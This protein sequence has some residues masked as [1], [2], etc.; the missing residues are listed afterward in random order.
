MCLGVMKMS[1]SLLSAFNIDIRKSRGINK[2]DYDVFTNKDLLDRFRISILENLSDRVDVDNLDKDALI[3]EVKVALEG[4]EV[5]NEERLYLYNL[6]DNEINGYG[7]LTELLVAKDID[8]I[9][10]N[11]CDEV[12]VESNGRLI[13]DNNVS[14]IN[15]KHIIRV[16][17][18]LISETGK[19]ID[20]NNPMVDAI[21]P[22]GSRVN[23]IVPPIS[24]HPTITIRKFKQNLVDMNTLIGNGTLTPY[25][26]EFLCAAM[27]AKLNII[28]S[29][30]T[31]CG[32]T[33]LL[34]T[35][36]NYI[37]EED[38]TIT[39]EDSRELSLRNGHVVSLETK[40]DI[41]GDNDITIRELVR[42]ALRMRPDR[43]IIGEIRGE[44]AFDLLQAMNTGC[45]GSMTTMHANSPKDAL[46]RLETMVLMSGFDVPIK[47]L[48]EYID[49]AIDV[50]VHMERMP[51]GKRKI[52]SIS[53]VDGIQDNE[54]IINNIFDFKIDKVLDDGTIEGKFTLNKR[55]PNVL[56]EMNRKGI[57]VV[58]YMFKKNK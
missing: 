54:L 49:S 40:N 37:K 39:I 18:S 36:S 13:K 17:Q 47:N 28:I 9:M 50:I 45:N 3:E 20:V 52:V 27:Q 48:R 56:K 25:M 6:I 43:I 26:A 15:D 24:L 35:L 41:Y 42:N 19:V 23:A 5:S 46:N 57:R 12:Y 31:S 1:K 22:D 33:S 16:V 51:D 44:E 34:N 14:F 58:D 10:V 11:G 53:E 55:I 8:E 30:G 7:P 4:Y 38:R 2:K 21:L 29:G 32:K